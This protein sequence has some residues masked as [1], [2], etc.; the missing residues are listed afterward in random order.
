M[1]DR[2]TRTFVS[3][4]VFPA[5]LMVAGA[6]QS[7]PAHQPQS[8]HEN[9]PAKITNGFTASAEVTAIAPAERQLTLREIPSEDGTMFDLQV[10]SGVRNFEQIAIGDMLRVRYQETLTVLKMPAGSVPTPVEGSLAAARAKTGAKPG[11]GI[12][13]RVNMRVRIESIDREREIVTFSL[14]SGELVARHLRPLK[15]GLRRGPEGRRRRADRLRRGAGARDRE[16]LG[17]C[18][19]WL[20]VRRRRPCHDKSP[21]RPSTLRR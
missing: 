19:G 10:D 14:A 16:D 20:R 21:R 6:C 15:A 11:A 9:K 7:E 4:L 17:A 13:R 8:V 3:R 1:N 18:C 5:I 12:A 2:S